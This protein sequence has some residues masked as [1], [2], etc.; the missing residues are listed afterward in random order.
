MPG[1]TEEDL[2]AP[3]E[4]E[5]APAASG[6]PE[7]GRMPRVLVVDDEAPILSILSRSLRPRFEVVTADDPVLALSLVERQP[8][9]SVIISDL[10]MPQMDGAEFLARVKRLAPSST[11]LALT[12]S[13]D[14]QLSPEDAFGILTKPCPLNLLHETVAAAVQNHWVAL[15]Q[16]G[17]TVAGRA[18]GSSGL[19]PLAPARR[20]ESSTRALLPS[21]GPALP[22]GTRLGLRLFG[23]S[24][25]LRPGVTTLGRSQSCHI[26]IDDPRIAARH[27]RFM[28]SFRGVTLQDVSGKGGVRLN[29]ERFAGAKYIHFGDW[30]GLGPFDAEVVALGSVSRDAPLAARVEE[31]SW[32]AV[33]G[34]AG[35]GAL[36]ILSGV[37]EKLF[38]RGQATDA[39]R[40]L[41]APLEDFLRR[42]E[43]GQ[44][45]SALDTE[46]AVD[47]ALRLAEET[48]SPRWIDYTLRVFSAAGRSVPPS[49]AERLEPL[50]AEL[51]SA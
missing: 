22:P 2:N 5:A 18:A 16:L 40:V 31:P 8:N 30:I 34:E 6:A 10:Q 45:P 4:S 43:E 7:A 12:A 1:R 33:G 47:L 29:G 35:S 14:R 21:S 26:V 23:N 27:A 28:S 20:H 48:R 3:P 46:L 50:C 51:A 36:E 41:S 25:E 9:F 49:I 38:H 44:R 39:D 13:L 37:A 24:V 15:R 19:R 42:C 17:A 11:R 32:S